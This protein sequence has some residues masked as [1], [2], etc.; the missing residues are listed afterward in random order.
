MEGKLREKKIDWWRS[1]IRPCR[2]RRVDRSRRREGRGNVRATERV[3]RV[4]SGMKVRERDMREW[5]RGEHTERESNEVEVE[6]KRKQKSPG[7]AGSERIQG[8]GE[9]RDQS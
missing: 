6:Y 1:K 9:P 2:V 8:E 5:E 4:T 7:G 3:G